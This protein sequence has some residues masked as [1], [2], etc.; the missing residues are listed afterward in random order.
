MKNVAQDAIWQFEVNASK[1]LSVVSAQAK[2][3]LLGNALQMSSARLLQSQGAAVASASEITLGA[4]GN[5]FQISGTTNIDR[6][7]STDWAGGS[8]INL[9][10]QGS[11]TVNH[12]TANNG[13]FKGLRLAGAANFAV[14]AA[15]QLTLQYD[16]VDLVWYELARAVI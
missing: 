3:L 10:F 12:A 13:A 6:I 8:I 9:H 1:Q 15:D 14:T 16:G 7:D 2:A 4:A 11:L 5:R